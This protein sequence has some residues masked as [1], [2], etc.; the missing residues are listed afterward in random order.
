MKCRKK[1]N[2]NGIYIDRRS[3]DRID[4]Y[5]VSDYQLERSRFDRPV[6][7]GSV[8]RR[9]DSFRYD[10]ESQP[11]IIPDFDYYGGKAHNP[12]HRYRC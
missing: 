12:E 6:L 3:S 9:I 4:P 11:G 10:G 5:Y 2:F 7:V 1:D 8:G